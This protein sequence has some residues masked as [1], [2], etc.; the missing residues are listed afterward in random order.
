VVLCQLH[1]KCAE[2]GFRFGFDLEDVAVTEPS[3]R[4]NSR[5]RWSRSKA[6]SEEKALRQHSR[7]RLEVL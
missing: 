6:A 7:E 2:N 5:Y 1:G 4:K 3:A